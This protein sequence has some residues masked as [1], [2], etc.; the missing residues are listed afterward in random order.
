MGGGG[1]GG[2]ILLNIQEAFTINSTKEGI[3]CDV[4]TQYKNR[5][6]NLYLNKF[7]LIGG[8]HPHG[9]TCSLDNPFIPVFFSILLLLY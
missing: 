2:N 4:G 1:G 8:A 7:D 9:Q 3:P 5:L 6:Q